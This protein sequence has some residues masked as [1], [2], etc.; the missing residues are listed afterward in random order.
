MGRWSCAE[1]G[2]SR[3]SRIAPRPGGGPAGQAI[4]TLSLPSSASGRSRA[5]RRWGGAIAEIRD[6]ALLEKMKALREETP[7]QSR[8]RLAGRI[9]KV[10]LIGLLTT[11][12]SYGLLRWAL[13]R[14]GVDVEAILRRATRGFP[15]DGIPEGL[16]YRPPAAQSRLLRRRIEEGSRKWIED[17]IEI[18]EDVASRL[19]SG[20]R[21]VGGEGSPHSHWVFPVAVPEGIEVEKVCGELR[22]A[23]FDASREAALDVIEAP[24]EHPGFEASVA[25]DVRARMV[26]LPLHP[27]LPPERREHL[28]ATLDACAVGALR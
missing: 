4:E 10:A 17:R 11:E 3:W 24:E 15:S 9:L 12:R 25:R 18:A 23:G 16:R 2:E 6:P 28:L 5:R 1:N 13:D 21:L 20:W 26:F 19:P 22:Q 27:P 7:V 14:N 8:W